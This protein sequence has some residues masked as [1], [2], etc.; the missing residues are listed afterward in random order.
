M[1]FS[2]LITLAALSLTNALPLS[3][4]LNTASLT[5]NG[6]AGAQ[7]TISVPLDGTVT[8]TN[9]ALSISSISTS[10]FDV[11]KNCKIHAVDVTP[12]LVVSF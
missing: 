11:G 2:T 7:Y 8:K 12:A 9:N 6:A 5:F 4:P 1:Q 10:G 3:P